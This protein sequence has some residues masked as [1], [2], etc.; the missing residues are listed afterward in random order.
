MIDLYDLGPIWLSSQTIACQV[1][2][3]HDKDRRTPLGG[4]G[5]HAGQ[6]QI[7]L[8]CW[9]NS[10]SNNHD[11]INQG[12][13]SPLKNWLSVHNLWRE[14]ELSWQVFKHPSFG[15]TALCFF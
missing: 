4:V 2:Q 7:A 5:M 14:L 3:Q 11:Q 12:M 9:G 15:V 1:E 8:H 13:N 10:W 6:K